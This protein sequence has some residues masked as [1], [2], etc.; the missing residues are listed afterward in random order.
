MSLIDKIKPKFWAE[1]KSTDDSH[2]TLFDY[3]GIWKYAAIGIS[4]IVILPLISLLLLYH[5]E[6]KENLRNELIRQVSCCSSNAGRSVAAFFSDRKTALC[7]IAQDNRFTDA[8][9]K[10]SIV[11]ILDRF[12]IASGAFADLE[13]I[14][15]NNETRARL[16]PKDLQGKRSANEGWLKE[17]NEKG[18]YVSDM[19]RDPDG[20]PHFLI[21]IRCKRSS[22]D[23]II[24][25]AAMNAETLNILT[26]AFEFSSDVDTFLINQEGILQT[27]SHSYGNT[28][29]KIPLSLIPVSRGFKVQELED[30]SGQ[31]LIIASAIIEGTPF[32]LMTV[33]PFDYR[34]D[35]M[36][37]LSKGFLLLFIPGILGVLIIVIGI[38]TSLVSRIYEAD[39]TRV[40]VLHNIQYTNK[41]ASIGRLAAGVAHEINN[42]L[43]IINEKLG[44]LKD[45]IG[46]KKDVSHSKLLNIVESMLSSVNRC[47]TVTHSLL[48]FAKHIDVRFEAVHIGPV[49]QEV[50]VFFK[51]ECEYRNIKVELVTPESLPSIECDLGQIEQVFFNII[52]NAIAAVDNGGKIEIELSTVEPEMLSIRIRDDGCGISAENLRHIF[53]PFFSTK[54]E[55]GSGLGLSITYGIVQK[56]GG[57]LDVKSKKGE[58]TTF[59]VSFPVKN[60]EIQHRGG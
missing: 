36:S 50:L 10:K 43:A 57:N 39:R 25:R 48:G 34:V 40:A 22:G 59:I 52:N 32:R 15:L 45:L 24:L 6:H 55:K 23:P 17:V 38:V 29:G 5:Y 54:G 7:F 20:D 27:S 4:A 3:A 37:Y 26:R 12:K 16:N 58:G 53:D 9:D 18:A 51:K 30:R 44:L 8:L 49:I 2:I 33:A 41:M 28:F 19:F 11:E 1:S 47:S 13:V 60:G 14:D 46:L 42:P 56:L 21:A 35:G 31:P